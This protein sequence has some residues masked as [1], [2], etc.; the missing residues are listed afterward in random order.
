VAKAPSWDDLLVV[1]LRRQRHGSRLFAR[2]ASWTN[3]IIFM[4]AST[5]LVIELGIV[6]YILLGWQFVL[7][8]IVGGLVM[9]MALSLLTHYFFSRAFR[10]DCVIGCSPIRRG[11]AGFAEKLA[12]TAG[13]T[14]QLLAAA[15]Y[16]LG[17]ITMLRKELVA[18]SWSRASS[19]CT[20]RPLVVTPVF[21]GH[22][23][24]TVIEN[25]VVAPCSRWCPSSAPSATFLWPQPCG[26]T[27][28]LSA[29]CQ[30][31][32]RRLVTLPL[33]LIYRASTA[34]LR[35]LDCS[36]CFGW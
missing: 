16:S 21:T 26:R 11:D 31:Y 24:L 29:G 30:F 17:D 36:S 15:Q 33:L 18:A 23:S 28:W 1:Q 4:I 2:G 12:R 32:L 3:S 7:A 13:P 6:M 25:A 22:G 5:N 14:R 35:R 34:R 27:A 20:C 10:T 8:Q 19:P 9:I